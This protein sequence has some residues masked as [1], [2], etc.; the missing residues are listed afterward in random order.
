MIPSKS[1]LDYYLIKQKKMTTNSIGSN[2]TAIKKEGEEA[3]SR[4]WA[5][6][7]ITDA[8]LTQLQKEGILP[9]KENCHWRSAYGH[10]APDPTG[11]ERVLLVSHLLRG[12]SLPPHPFSNLS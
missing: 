4:N 9:P 12:L 2:S 6:S 8:D 3:S 10:P 1:E 5:A 7:T 11:D